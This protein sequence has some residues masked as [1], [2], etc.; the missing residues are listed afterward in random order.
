VL[1][2]L[3]SGEWSAPA[4]G[5]PSR[6]RARKQLGGFAAETA[7]LAQ[8]DPYFRAAHFGNQYEPCHVTKVCH[9]VFQAVPANWQFKANCGSHHYRQSRV[10]SPALMSQSRRQ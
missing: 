6:R 4:I 7:R 10:R 5:V 8:T 1:V 3:W 9:P 2:I